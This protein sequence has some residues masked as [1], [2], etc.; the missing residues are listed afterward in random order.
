LLKES[1]G[2]Y[3]RSDN[4][5]LRFKIDENEKLYGLGE[6]AIDFSLVGNRYNLYNRPKYGYELPA[7]NLNYSVPLVMSSKKYLLYF[8]NP[9]KGYADIGELEPKV[10]EWGAIGGLIKYFVIA[11]YDHYDIMRQWGKLTGT[12]PI[13]PRWALGTFNPEWAIA[14]NMKQIPLSV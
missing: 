8:D 5:G 7:L 4:N 6:R 13:P 1:N 14:H 10:L 11:G 9:Q 3:Q 12:Q 2:Y